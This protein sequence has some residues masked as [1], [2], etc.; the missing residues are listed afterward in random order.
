MDPLLMRI[1]LSL[2]LFISE[3][4]M[5]DKARILGSHTLIAKNY[6]RGGLGPS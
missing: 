6:L 3:V 4:L 2:F 5:L 1:T